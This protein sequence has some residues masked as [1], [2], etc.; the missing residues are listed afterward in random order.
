MDNS[1]FVDRRRIDR[2]T[3]DPDSPRPNRRRMRRRIAARFPTADTPHRPRPPPRYACDMHATPTPR[4]ETA[5]AKP[6]N[7]GMARDG[8]VMRESSVHVEGMAEFCGLLGTPPKPG[9][10]AVACSPELLKGAVAPTYA[11]RC[12]FFFI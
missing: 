5:T 3:P 8:G 10:R 11:D 7:R 9:T 12:I 2:P 1:V 4:R 6:G